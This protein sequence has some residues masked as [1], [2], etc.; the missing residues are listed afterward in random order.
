[1]K[2]WIDNQILR[3]FDGRIIPID[4]EIATACAGLHVPRTRPDRD[5]YIAATALVHNFT[6][7]TRNTRDFEPMGV[8]LLNPWTTP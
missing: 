2:V 1:L 3:E 5:A 6:V 4:L 7:V 8:K